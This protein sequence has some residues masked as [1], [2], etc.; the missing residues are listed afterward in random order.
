MAKIE[1][2]AEEYWKL[3]ENEAVLIEWGM[4][5][6]DVKKAKSATRACIKELER[7]Q[8]ASNEYWSDWLVSRRNFFQNILLTANSL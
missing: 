4:A 8:Q 2:A 6:K 5:T 3:E 1:E 7:R